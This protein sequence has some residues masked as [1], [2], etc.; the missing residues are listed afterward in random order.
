MLVILTLCG[1][2]CGR[3]REQTPHRVQRLATAIGWLVVVLATYGV[4]HLR[5]ATWLPGIVLHVICVLAAAFLG[6]GKD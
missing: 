5:F 2:F 3:R 4:G 1:K 6:E